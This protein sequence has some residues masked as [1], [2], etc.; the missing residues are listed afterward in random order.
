MYF[1]TLHLN[2]NLLDYSIK[3]RGVYIAGLP[4]SPENSRLLLRALLYAAN[5]EAVENK[6]WTSNPLT[7]LNGYKTKPMWSVVNNTNEPQQ[8]TLNLHGKVIELNLSPSEIKW[9]KGD[10]DE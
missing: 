5:K 9:I 2:T 10:D 3:G 4:Y 7:E 8:T 6:T 1:L